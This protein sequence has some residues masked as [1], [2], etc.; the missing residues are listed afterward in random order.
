MHAGYW[1][2]KYVYRMYE[3]SKCKFSDEERQL[4]SIMH[5]LTSNTPLEVNGQ[6]ILTAADPDRLVTLQ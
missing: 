3:I 6:V 2:S 4:Q 1:D 5:G